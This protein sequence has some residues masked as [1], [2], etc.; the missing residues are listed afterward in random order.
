MTDT[1]KL[2]SLRAAGETGAD[3]SPGDPLCKWAYEEIMRYR[4]PQPFTVNPLNNRLSMQ[5]ISAGN[6]PRQKPVLAM[7]FDSL[8]DMHEAA[9]FIMA[10]R[11]ESQPTAWMKGYT[12]PGTP[13]G[14][15]EHDIECV[16]GDDPPPGDGWLPLF[17]SPIAPAYSSPA[18]AH[19]RANVQLAADKALLN[20]AATRFYKRVSARV[21][22]LIEQ[23]EEVAR[24]LRIA[25]GMEGDVAPKRAACICPP[26]QTIITC[27]ACG[28]PYL[29]KVS[30]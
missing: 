26:G 21:P 12:S 5:E 6:D 20:G 28:H 24:P 25:L 17:R 22:G 1:D 11:H 7:Q 16:Y 10:M 23:I 27:P 14:P 9:R 4:E 30:E 18:S 13:N 15:P 29:A 8:N 2:E 3:L 19:W